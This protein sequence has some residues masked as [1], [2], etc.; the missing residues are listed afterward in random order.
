MIG[1]EA[2]TKIRLFGVIRREALKG[3]LSKARQRHD[4]DKL[5][6]SSLLR[7]LRQWLLPKSTDTS[8]PIRHKKESLQDYVPQRFLFIVKPLS[9]DVARSSARRER[10]S[11]P[12]YLAV[13][14]IS[15]PPHST[16]LPSLLWSITRRGDSLHPPKIAA[17]IRI[18]LGLPKRT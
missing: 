16:T 18:L 9:D 3:T 14:R 17:K 7:L 12:R 1:I 8:R 4:S 15:R 11:N 13:Q 6:G 10:D 2:P 5:P